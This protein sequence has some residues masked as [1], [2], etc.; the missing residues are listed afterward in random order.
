MYRYGR[1]LV[2]RHG[3]V[4]GN[5]NINAGQVGIPGIPSITV[6][7]AATAAVACCCCCC[8]IAYMHPPRENGYSPN[9]RA[10]GTRTPP[11][12]LYKLYQEYYQ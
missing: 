12:Q 6:A 10:N 1:V 2:A 3:P 5:P 4:I 9:M 11:P 7:A 8:T